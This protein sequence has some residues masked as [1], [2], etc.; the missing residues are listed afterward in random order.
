MKI[1]LA[2]PINTYF[3]LN[4]GADPSQVNRC[5]TETATVKD[6]ANEYQG[7]A[8]IEA[9][10]TQARKTF[11]FTSTPLS[12]NKQGNQDIVLAEVRGNFPG[13]PI[14]L[15]YAFVVNNGKIHA[16]EIF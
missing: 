9:W 15:H 7:L 6:E 11:Q 12:T 5:F 14:Q 10:L 4:N 3:E 2:E 16:L 8:A 1:Q 13:S